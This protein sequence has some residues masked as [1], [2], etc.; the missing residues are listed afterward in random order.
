MLIISFNANGYFFVALRKGVF[1]A[2][3]LKLESVSVAL[4]SKAFK[5]GCVAFDS[6]SFE[7]KWV[8]SVSK[9]AES[10][11]VSFGFVLFETGCVV[12]ASISV[13]L[14]EVSFSLFGD[15]TFRCLRLLLN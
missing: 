9:N 11:W 5:S 4:V 1:F 12:F 15:S 8:A 7:S 2:V 6:V 10:E 3:S 14:A 13:P